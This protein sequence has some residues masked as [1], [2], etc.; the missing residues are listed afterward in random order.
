MLPIRQANVLEINEF[1]VLDF[2]RDQGRTT[3]GEV[4]RELGLSRA[5]VS[6]IVRRLETAGALVE[7]AGGSSG[8]GRPR[9]IIEYNF[10]A[11]SVIAVDVGALNCRVALADL[12]GSRIRELSAPTL[13]RG[14]PFDTLRQLVL[15]ARHVA[16]DLGLPVRSLVV[17]LPAIVDPDSERIFGSPWDFGGIDLVQRLTADLDVPI[18]VDNEANLAAIAQAWRGLGRG[19]R[20]F[21][22]LS[23]GS[24]V[25]GAIVANGQLVR[26]RHSAAGEFG[27]LARG[28]ADLRRGDPHATPAPA[29]E[30][31]VAARG[32]AQRAR[33]LLAREPATSPLDHALD[34]P[35]IFEAAAQGAPWAIEVVDETI[36]LV[37]FAVI[38]IAAVADPEVIFFDGG[39][40]RSLEPFLV[41][42]AERV[43]RRVPFAPRLRVSELGPNS[44]V[45]GGVAAALELARQRRAPSAALRP[46]SAVWN[47]LETR[48]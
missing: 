22:L 21:A 4:E 9:D 3:R 25:G 43:S 23:I 47:P 11:G 30:D 39:I 40:G 24:G 12:G 44:T 2:I 19:L 32:I 37:A 42:I 48:R 29:L 31:A 7:S 45:I 28:L 17:G 5:S 8:L 14:S 6:R 27:Y 41:G 16:S 38:A 18:A 13:A 1:L 36:D 10:Q 35:A 34:P 15:D 46:L 26:G 33:T 20:D